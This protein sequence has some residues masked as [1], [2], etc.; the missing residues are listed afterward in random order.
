M[1]KKSKQILQE[2]EKKWKE[3]LEQME[4]SKMSSYCTV[5][6]LCIQN[7]TDLIHLY[8]QQEEVRETQDYCEGVLVS[9]IDSLQR[10]YMSVRELIRG[11]GEEAAAQVQTSLQTLQDKMEDIKKRDSELAQTDSDVHFLQVL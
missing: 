8:I 4:V 7:P 2:Q 1:Q 10:H 5:C 6:T 9:V 3:T 11:H